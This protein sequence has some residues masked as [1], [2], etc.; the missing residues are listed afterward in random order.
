MQGSA[1]L[2]LVVMPE[3]FVI[4]CI[5]VYISQ[6]AVTTQKDRGPMSCVQTIG[7]SQVLGLVLL[8]H[9]HELARASSSYNF[10]LGDV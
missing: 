4:C 9:P 7:T 5:Y 6:N 1:N 10:T 2:L 8:W 3:S